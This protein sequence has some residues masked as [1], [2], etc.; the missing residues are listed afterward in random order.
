[1]TTASLA[2]ATSFFI[3]P[4]TEE[5]RLTDALASAAHVVI[6]DWEDMVP[7]ERKTEAR[8]L[9]RQLF[10]APSGPLKVVRINAPDAPEFEVDIKALADVNIDGILVPKGVPDLIERLGPEGPPLLVLVETGAGVR[11]AYETASMPRV[12]GLVIAPG[13]LSKDLRIALRPDGQ[14]LLYTRSKLVVDCAAAGIR[15]PIDIPSA[16]EGDALRAEVAY[17]QSLGLGGKLCL[18]PGQAELINESFAA[19]PT[20]AAAH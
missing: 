11:L 3:A 2:T 8:D 6:A 5:Q 4:G 16:S 7:P 1:M 12:A 18:K 17:A 10:A 13:D 14:S 15:S 20:P 19:A 9:V